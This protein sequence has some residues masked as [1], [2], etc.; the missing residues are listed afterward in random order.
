MTK[1]NI[2]S[3]K[4]I[5]NLGLILGIVMIVSC[6]D[7]TETGKRD[8]NAYYSGIE[9]VGLHD[10]VVCDVS[11][12][13]R[14]VRMPLSKLVDSC[15]IIYLETKDASIL[16]QLGRFAVSDNYLCVGGSGKPLKLFR[17]DGSYIC[18]IGKIGRGPGE[19]NF[20]PIQ[21]ILDEKRNSI[22]MITVVNVDKILR[23]DLKGNFVEAISLRYK[24]PKARMWIE[25]DT[26]TIASMVFNE[27]IPIV[28]QQTF[29][30]E[31]IQELPRDKH[32]VA[33]PDYS[34]AMF[35]NNRPDYDFQILSADTLFHYNAQ[36]N[37]LEPQLV[38]PP[39]TNSG[40]QL[41]LEFPKHY[42]GASYVVRKNK[43]TGKIESVDKYNV[44]I[45]KKTLETRC[46]ELINDFYGG[47]SHPNLFSCNNNMFI[48]STPAFKLMNEIK[49]ILKD[50]K[51]SLKNKQKLKEILSHLHVNDNDVLFVGKLKQTGN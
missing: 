23:Y 40:G 17:R 19:Y 32:L 50:N 26:I 46:Y 20:T 11:K 7:K 1:I 37:E 45:N 51:L 35:S 34:N 28:Y 25:A 31:L 29:E 3:I 24:S 36:E 14:K 8:P 38:F 18:D 39:F 6:R 47:I 48:A 41:L 42:I 44:I 13:K 49:E 2:K 12:I 10:V 9:K 21:I 4:Q 30:G 27:E 15:E 43:N 5:L 22:F 16:P 33:K